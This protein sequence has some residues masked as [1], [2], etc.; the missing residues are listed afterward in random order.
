MIPQ[1]FV[2]ATMNWMRH[3][4]GIG[5]TNFRIGSYKSTTPATLASKFTSGR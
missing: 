2:D 1:A 3:K 4:E 5:V